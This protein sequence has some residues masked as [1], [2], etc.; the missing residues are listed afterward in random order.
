LTL[1]ARGRQRMCKQAVRSAGAVEKDGL[2]RATPARGCL[3][4][5][6]RLVRKRPRIELMA[7]RRA[8]PTALGQHD[9]DGLARDELRLIDRLRGGAR[10]DAAAAIVSEE[11]GIRDQLLAHELLQPR[12][13]LQNLLELI[14][15]LRK[16]LLLAANLHLLELREVTQLRF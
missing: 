13:A 15:L 16:L 9:R 1:P 14:A 10:G 7:L 6:A 3:E 5:I 12:L 11:I 4:R 8:N 2:L